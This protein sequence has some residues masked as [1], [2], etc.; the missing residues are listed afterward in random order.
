M[1]KLILIL[2]LACGG[3]SAISAPR[4]KPLRPLQIVADRSPRCRRS[5]CTARLLE[6][7]LRRGLRRCDRGGTRRGNRTDTRTGTH[8]GTRT[9]AGAFA[10]GSSVSG[11]GTGASAS[12][13]RGSVDTDAQHL[14]GR[15]ASIDR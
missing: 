6:W 10:S 12:A 13:Y 1:L 11:A 7:E 9:G 14:A 8:T 5:D 4:F 2:A 3:E 15:R